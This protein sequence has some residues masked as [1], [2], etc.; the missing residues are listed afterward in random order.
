MPRF[1]MIKCPTEAKNIIVGRYPPD[2]KTGARPRI[3]PEEG[4]T[5]RN[6]FNIISK[7]LKALGNSHERGL[8]ALADSKSAETEKDP[9]E[10]EV[11]DIIYTP[12]RSHVTFTRQH[13]RLK[14][15]TRRCQN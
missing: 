13:T 3:C 1:D 10:L 6:H 9:I 14:I 11:D 8:K 7:G 5:K 2:R 4:D 12:S 15:N